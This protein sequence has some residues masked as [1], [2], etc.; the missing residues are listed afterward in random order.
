MTVFIG[1]FDDLDFPKCK[2]NTEKWKIEFNTKRANRRNLLSKWN[3]NSTR[4]L[5]VTQGTVF[6]KSDN[7][8]SMRMLSPS[9]VI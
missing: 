8:N 6:D 1:T 4:N 3:H 9:K 7:A 5:Q 2:F